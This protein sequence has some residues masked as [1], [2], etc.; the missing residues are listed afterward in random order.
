VVVSDGANPVSVTHRLMIPKHHIKLRAI[1]GKHVFFTPYDV[2]TCIL[3][4]V[5]AAIV[6]LTYDLYGFTI[7]EDVDYLKALRVVEFIASLGGNSGDAL[8]LDQINIYGAMPDILALSLQQLIPALSFDSRHLVSALF[9]MAGVYYVYRVGTAF[10]TPAVGFFGALFLACNP[11]WFGYMFFNA[12][13]I[14]FATTLLA[15]FFYC[16]SALTGRYERPWIWAKIGLAIGLLAT[17]K[18]IGILVL[19]LIVLVTLVVL[20]AIPQATRLQ[21]N[22][23]FSNS[24]LKTAISATVGCFVCF[25]VFWPQF[26]F[27]SPAQLVNIVGQFMSYETWEGNV[28]IHGDYFPAASIPWYYMLVYYSISMPL[29]LLALTGGGAVYGVLQREPFIV[30][31]VVVCIIFFSYQAITGARVAFNGYRHFLFLLPFTMLIAAYPIGRLLASHL[32]WMTRIASLSVAIVGT[33]AATVSI[34][35]LFPYQYS[36]YNMLVGG[37]PGADG[38]YEIDVWRSALR[39]AVREIAKISHGNEIIRIH[40]CGSH[41][42]FAAYPKFREVRELEDPDY[43]VILR[44]C[45]DLRTS[46]VPDLPLVGGIR[47]QGV[48]FAAIY[49]RR[50]M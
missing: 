46:Q 32:P 7:D 2:L 26:F 29:F 48:L 27:W 19:A 5:L 23:V 44:R 50:K 20:L 43:I 40:T 8:E 24:L 18:V 35:Q 37:V 45:L 3:L 49:S 47:R 10:I 42:N 6:A 36:F 25:S 1:F 15:A 33:F 13:D 38:R 14:P 16:L 34:Y 21:I 17:T 12:K 39:E 28:L 31:L 30:S 4:L 22:G 11:M 9:G 41:M